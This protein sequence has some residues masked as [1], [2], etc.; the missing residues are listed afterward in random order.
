MIDLNNRNTKE[1]FSKLIDTEIY[2][3]G[4]TFKKQKE[5]NSQVFRYIKYFSSSSI[6]ATDVNGQS[7]CDASSELSSVT[8]LLDKL[9]FNF[10]SLETL[11]TELEEMKKSISI[12]DNKTITDIDNY[13]KMSTA[14]NKQIAANSAKIEEFLTDNNSFYYSS[15]IL[16]SIYNKASVEATPVSQTE[17]NIETFTSQTTDTTTN[18]LDNAFT[19]TDIPIVSDTEVETINEAPVEVNN[20]EEQTE[21][22]TTENSVSNNTAAITQDVPVILPEVETLVTTPIY[23]EN[24][25]DENI[26]EIKEIENIET[27]ENISGEVAETPSNLTPSTLNISE[28]DGKV[29]LPYT[30]E[31]LDEILQDNPKK[32]ASYEDVIDKVYTKSIKDYKNPSIARFK[33]AYNLM[34]KKENASISSALDLAVELFSNYNLHPAVIS[35]C[36]N[37]NELDIYLSCIEYNELDDFNFF[38]VIFN[39]APTAKK[40][41]KLNTANTATAKAGK[42]RN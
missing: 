29:I 19:D 38:K 14:T 23:S 3:V 34:R 41:A 12:V 5:L 24:K 30:I 22:Q 27:T 2:N 39:I 16:E 7:V 32:Y 40:L 17:T 4:I 42:H 36:K 6:S 37:L 13:N 25:N 35:A 11:V 10:S 18:E 21:E 9:S 28:S 20:E 33:E 26:E 15:N 8:K 31:E 1:Y